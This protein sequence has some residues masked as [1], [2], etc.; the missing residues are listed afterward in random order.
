MRLKDL[1]E[2]IEHKVYA[3]EDVEVKD[4]VC[5]SKSVRS[6]SLFAAVKGEHAPLKMGPCAC[7]LRRRLPI[8]RSPRLWCLM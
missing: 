4:I 6:G 7:L 5:D 3:M 8:L 1:I 2:P